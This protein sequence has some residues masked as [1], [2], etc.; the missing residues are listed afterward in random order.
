[1]WN[2]WPF[3]KAAA[4]CQLRRTDFSGHFARF[5]WNWRTLPRMWAGPRSRAIFRWKSRVGQCIF[6]WIAPENFIMSRCLIWRQASNG[7]GDISSVVSKK[8]RKVNIKT[9]VSR[10]EMFLQ[11]C[12]PNGQKK[13]H[14]SG[15]NQSVNQSTTDT[16]KL[17]TTIYKSLKNPCSILRISSRY[18]CRCCRWNESDRKPSFALEFWAT[19][20][21]QPPTKKSIDQWNWIY[22]V[23]L[24][25]SINQSTEEAHSIRCVLVNQSINQ[26]SVPVVV[27][28][29]WRI[30]PAA[31]GATHPPECPVFP[32]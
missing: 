14:T 7:G 16:I 12:E 18:R 29:L 15:P 28:G 32:V 5:K 13:I 9:P 26:S 20:H 19:P 11:K 10:E 1:M 25:Q 30:I 21:G 22:G 3:W 6:S 17:F 31:C 4:P 8:R 23:E 27:I 24:Y 2:T